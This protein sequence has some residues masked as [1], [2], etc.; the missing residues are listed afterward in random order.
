[1]PALAFIGIGVVAADG[2]ILVAVG[3]GMTLPVVAVAGLLLGFG[4]G[5]GVAPGLFMGG[6][7]VPSSQLGPVFA[8]VEL[9]R[10]EAAFLIGPILLAIA[11]QVGSLADGLRFA[12][13]VMTVFTVVV[14]AGITGL[15]LLGGK[16]PHAPDLPA[17]LDGEASAFDS[18]PVAA[19]LRE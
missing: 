7:S 10:S 9:L 15:L 19:V 1:M 5:A 17:W 8:L 2:A 16:R 18:P 14:G 6:L 3:P 12:I 13:V 11:M 4:A